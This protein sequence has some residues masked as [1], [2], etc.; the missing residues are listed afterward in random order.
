MT[1]SYTTELELPLEFEY[2][3]DSGVPE[4]LP[5]LSGPGLPAEPPTIEITRIWLLDTE[6]Q[7]VCQ[8]PV[9]AFERSGRSYLVREQ[10][11]EEVK[12]S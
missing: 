11:E 9:N 1:R 10:L 4:V 12:S 7:R 5:S 2:T 8:L 3:A 6:G